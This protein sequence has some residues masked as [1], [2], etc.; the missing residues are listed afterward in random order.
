MLAAR[1]AKLVIHSGSAWPEV[2]KS[3]LELTL[4]R[5]NHPI[6]MTKRK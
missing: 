5:R 4:L 2:R 3:E 6:P 1:N